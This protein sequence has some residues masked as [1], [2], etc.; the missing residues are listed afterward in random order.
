K[1]SDEAG[2]FGV[3]SR[4]ELLLLFRRQDHDH[5]A[6]FHFRELLNLAMRLQVGF[7]TLK[8]THADVLVGHFT[9]T[10]TQGDLRLITVFQE[11]DQ[12]AQ[13]DVVVAII[14]TRTEFDFL[15]GDYLLLQLGFVRLLLFRI[16]ELTVVHEA[17]NRWSRIRSDF[18]QVNV[19]LFRETESFGQAYDAQRFIVYTRQTHFGVGDLAI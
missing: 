3:G 9:A 4:K 8:H 12:V 2:P 10:E 18:H 11:L 13:L 19:R 1:A 16:L 15:H 17:A 6:T 14:G 7:Q 5:L